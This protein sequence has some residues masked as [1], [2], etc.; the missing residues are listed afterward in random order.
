MTIFGESAGSISVHAHLAAPQ[1]QGLFRAA[2]AQSGSLLMVHWI[3][4]YRVTENNSQRLR[5]MLKCDEGYNPA[6]SLVCLQSLSVDEIMMVK[7]THKLIQVLT[8]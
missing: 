4:K 2:I 7:A 1:T 3:N 8:L 5:M 6:T